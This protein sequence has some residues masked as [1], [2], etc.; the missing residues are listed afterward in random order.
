MCAPFK[1]VFQKFTIFILSVYILQFRSFRWYRVLAILFRLLI[2]ALGF[3]PSFAS[4]KNNQKY[5]YWESVKSGRSRRRS[6]D[7]NS[8]LNYMG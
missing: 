7:E 4:A 2:S 8:E 6:P 5:I 3:C 1:W